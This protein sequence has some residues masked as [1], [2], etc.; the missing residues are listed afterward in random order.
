MLL[1]EAKKA[2]HPHPSNVFVLMYLTT[3]YQLEALVTV[4]QVYTQ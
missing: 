1:P 2:K 3:I 4:D